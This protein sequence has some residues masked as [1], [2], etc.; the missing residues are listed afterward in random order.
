MH[1]TAPCSAESSGGCYDT[2]ARSASAGTRTMRLRLRVSL[3]Y[4][5]SHGSDREGMSVSPLAANVHR[6]SSNED[7]VM[8]KI[9]EFYVPTSLQKRVTPQSD[10]RKGKV[11]EFC[12]IGK[13]PA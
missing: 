4:A 10:S 11:I 7:M 2:L 12:A 13:K 3:F 8:A 1:L 6:S 5:S 9:T